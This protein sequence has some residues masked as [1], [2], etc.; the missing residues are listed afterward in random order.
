MEKVRSNSQVNL[1][2]D[3]EGRITYKDPLH[4]PSVEWSYDKHADVMVISDEELEKDRYKHIRSTQVVGTGQI[5]LPSNLVDMLSRPIYIG[6]QI[7][8]L[9]HEDM[10][11]DDSEDASSQPNSVYLLTKSQVLKFMNER[12]GKPS[13]DSLRE[14]LQETPAFLPPVQ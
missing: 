9:A 11:P 4:G 14:K 12:P 5:R 2:S 7:A 3:L 1:P 8:Y 6:L 13:G 10:L